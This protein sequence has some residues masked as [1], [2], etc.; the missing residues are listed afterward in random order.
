VYTVFQKTKAPN[1][2]LLLRQ[3]VT[4]F[5]FYRQIPRQICSKVIIK[6]FV[7]PFA[8][9]FRF[10]TDYMDS[11]DCFADTSEHVRFFTFLF[12]IFLLVGS[13]R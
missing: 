4:D 2:W 8:F 3:I 12:S 11:P 10:R 6:H 1:L 5:H 9:F 13:V 7:T